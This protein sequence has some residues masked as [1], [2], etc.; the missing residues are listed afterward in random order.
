MADWLRR[1]FEAF[2]PVVVLAL[3]AAALVVGVGL[4]I[5][6]PEGLR[7]SFPRAPTPAALAAIVSLA[8]LFRIVLGADYHL[9]TVL[10]DEL[11]YSGLAKGWAL[12]GEP[13]FRGN[14]EVGY[15]TLYPLLIA[16]AFALAPDGA[17]ALEVVR[18]M[19]AIAMAATAIP[20]YVLA[21][22]AVPSGWALGV[23]LLTVAA[24]WTAYSALTLTEWLFYPVF[25]AFA[26][27]LA[28][29]L[30]RPT[31]LRQAGLLALLVALVA[32]RSQGLALAAATV[33]AIF[34]Y[35]GA[36]RFTPTF[37]ALGAG[38]AFGL[39]ATAAGLK[40]PTGTYDPLFDSL[41]RV[42]GMLKWS[43]W[44]IGSF[45]LALGVVALAA[46]PV[47]IRLML[48]RAERDGVRAAGAVAV[49]LSASLLASVA[50]LS[51]SPFGLDRLHERSLFFVTPLML[52]CFAYWLSRGL[53]RPRTLAL[54]S[55][56]AAVGL[57]AAVPGELVFESS[58]VDLPSGEF[59]LGLEE[60]FPGIDYRAW[61]TAIAAAGAA[62]FLLARRPLFPL[63]TVVLAFA[64][65]T[66]RVDYHDPLTG[67]QARALS[68][69][70]RALP[71][72]SG[73]TLVNLGVP[74]S[75]EPCASA[76]WTEQQWL[77]VWTEYLNSRIAGVRWLYQPNRF[78]ALASGELTVGEGGLILDRG[79]PFSPEYLV[80][81]S[82]QRIAGD[83]ISRF[84]L[85]SLGAPGLQHGASLTV[86]HVE[87]PLR[88]FD[89]P[90]PLPPRGD[91][92]GC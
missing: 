5:A 18:V 26:A 10:G 32:I 17:A 66:A 86:W 1:G 48:S 77:L 24:P 35:G 39:A 53:E 42:G 29:T 9:P 85:S 83:P 75:T 57:A 13:V 45:E 73:A 37:A 19:G 78:D 2:D 88:I 54:A 21:R 68:W 31:L 34:L 47:A 25:V 80:I 52:V 23:A 82:R 46:F 61:A 74:Y 58:A 91:G 38:V 70:D 56:V 15:S 64:A 65:V 7:V 72:G 60:R 67:T 71:A 49:A 89:R 8:A 14:V 76:A 6:R 81:D 79:E 16:P 44:S 62:V 92:R 22:R 33:A 11:V 4:R 90:S 55:A 40:L 28:S 59:F 51:A 3:A 12:Y 30:E 41:A 69:I 50:L 20:A 36:R 27:A 43:A 84:F 63:L 87:P